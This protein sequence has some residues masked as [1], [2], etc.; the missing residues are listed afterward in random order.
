MLIT[1]HNVF[2]PFV[3]W[4]I[5]KT[6]YLGLN[7]LKVSEYL[8]NLVEAD[9]YEINAS[10]VP[11][12][13]MLEIRYQAAKYGLDDLRKE[14]KKIYGGGSLVL[15]EAADKGVLEHQY[16]DGYNVYIVK[17]NSDK[18]SQCFQKTYVVEGPVDK[19]GSEII[20]DLARNLD[21]EYYKH[22]WFDVINELIGNI[23]H[24]AKIKKK[25]ES[26]FKIIVGSLRNG[27]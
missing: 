1:R 2:N 27:L 6:K 22:A 20:T 25:N 19:K 17:I 4:L 10:Y 24:Y 26:V 21:D 23:V 8:S 15:L 11:E 14:N 18:H 5:P 16:R 12:D 9:R 13:G 7:P 3:R